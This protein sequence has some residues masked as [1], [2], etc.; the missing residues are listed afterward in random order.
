MGNE[1][2]LVVAGQ[3]VTAH[4]TEASRNARAAYERPQA[5]TLTDRGRISGQQYTDDMPYIPVFIGSV[6]KLHRLLDEAN[7][8]AFTWKCIAGM[9]AGIIVLVAV[10]VIAANVN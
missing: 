7:D 4:E 10:A 5:Q 2:P 1:T 3:G 6:A 9:L 8:R